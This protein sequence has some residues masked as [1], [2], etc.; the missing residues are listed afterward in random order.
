[1]RASGENG[2]SERCEEKEQIEFFTV[3]FVDFKIRIGK[4]NNGKARN[5]DQ[6]V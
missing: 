5:E 4:C 3:A 2:A 1:M 6:S